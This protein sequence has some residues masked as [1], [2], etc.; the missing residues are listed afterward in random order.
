[1]IFTGS[2]LFCP[3]CSIGKKL[4]S[5]V[6]DAKH[7]GEICPACERVFSAR[8]PSNNRHYASEKGYRRA[9]SKFRKERRNISVSTAAFIDR[10]LKTDS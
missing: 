10:A 5:T 6:T 1:M 8:N 7:G 9:L 3:D 2:I 4:I